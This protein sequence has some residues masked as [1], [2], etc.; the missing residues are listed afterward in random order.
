MEDQRSA[1]SDEF[2]EIRRALAE[3]AG[4]SWPL[5][6]RHALSRLRRARLLHARAAWRVE[7]IEGELRSSLLSQ[8][9]L[10][11]RR[12]REEVLRFVRISSRRLKC[13]C[14]DAIFTASIAERRLPRA[15]E[16]AGLS[17]EIPS[18]ALAGYCLCK[19][20]I[21]ELARALRRGLV[22]LEGETLETLAVALLALSL[23]CVGGEEVASGMR[24]LLSR[25]LRTLVSRGEVRLLN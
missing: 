8:R 10:G 3:L 18:G 25:G 20:V 19:H 12:R 11:A 23:R 17:I 4:S 22:K 24:G 9:L 16:A 14:E 15:A 2:S 7:V 6:S 1:S 5:I 21:S 13:T